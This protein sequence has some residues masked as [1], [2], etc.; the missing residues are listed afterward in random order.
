MID[1][2]NFDYD[3]TNNLMTFT[4]TSNESKSFIYPELK[5]CV[6]KLQQFGIKEIDF[7]IQVKEISL[8]ILEKKDLQEL[9]KIKNE[10]T[11]TKPTNNTHTVKK[12]IRSSNYKYKQ[13]FGKP[14]YD[15]LLDLEPNAQNIIIHG[16][17]MDKE[18]KTSKTGRKIFYI[19]LTDNK[20]SIRC[21]YF[22]KN[23]QACEF[24]DLTEEELL[25]DNVKELKESKINVG[26]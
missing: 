16:M 4:T 18:F 25:Q 14:S 1:T 13:S 15:S 2:K 12:P 8:E 9:E 11:Q 5:Y 22:S 6:S 10:E 7:E 24:D 19:D 26:D 23:E 20:S 21:V 3:E 17:V